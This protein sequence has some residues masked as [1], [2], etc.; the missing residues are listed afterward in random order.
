MGPSG[1]GSA[2][3]VG[4]VRRRRAADCGVGGQGGDRALRLRS[5][6]ASDRRRRH[7][8]QPSPG[9]GEGCGP[10]GNPG[11]R[12]HGNKQRPGTGDHAPRERSAPRRGSAEGRVAHRLHA[13]ARLLAKGNRRALR[14]LGGADMPA[15]QAARSRARDPGARGEKRQAHR[16]RARADRALSEGHPGA[17]REGSRHPR[18]TRVIGFAD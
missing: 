5:G 8:G 12:L 7:R 2:D 11:A 1:N 16:R 9:G 13:G 17:V 14:R 15:S 10:E 3:R 6:K 18:G 4:E